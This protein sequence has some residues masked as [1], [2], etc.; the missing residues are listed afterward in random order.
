MGGPPVMHDAQLAPTPVQFDS[1]GV[2]CAADLWLPRQPS[3]VPAVVLANGFSGTKDWIVPRFA[4]G[5]AAAGLAALTFDYRHLG[6]SAGQPRQLVDPQRQR[7]D[8]RAAFAYLCSRPEVDAQ[9]VALWGTSLGGSHVVEFAAGEPRIAAVVCTMPALD[10]VRGMDLK[11]KVAAAGIGRGATAAVML[12]L[13]GAAAQDALRGA[14]GMPPRYLAVYGPPGQAFFTDAALADR[15]R[16]VAAS[17]PTWKN[18][19]AARFL[20]HAPRYRPGTLERIRAP[21]FF[22]LAARDLDVSPAFIKELVAGRPLRT[23]REYDA[24][25]F[26]LYHAPLFEQ[27][28]ADQQAFLVEALGV[29]P[30]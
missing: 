11:A 2:T 4:A 7:A 8:L 18:A 22:S 20:F 17:S 5:F 26:D 1:Q 27:V 25:H 13:A 16:T 29:R 10:A 28:V 3:P 9:R 30:N 6:L 14:L 23:V 24:G 15:F 21:M 19:V 12:R